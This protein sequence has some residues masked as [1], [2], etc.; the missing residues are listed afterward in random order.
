MKTP[1]SEKTLRNYFGMLW[2]MTTPYM[3][4]VWEGPKDKT[5]ED[6]IQR[7][8]KRY[9]K[10]LNYEKKLS[11]CLQ[12]LVDVNDWDACPFCGRNQRS[13]VLFPQ[14]HDSDCPVLIADEII[15]G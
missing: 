8:I 13:E 15:N 10:G 11:K 5:K 3:R 9:Y 2:D 12:A 7:N 1:K 14:E 4:E 6:Y